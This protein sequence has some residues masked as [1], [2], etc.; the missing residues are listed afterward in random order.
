MPPI[1]KAR[2]V[3]KNVNFEVA[4]V[5]RLD[6]LLGPPLELIHDSRCLKL[7]GYSDGVAHYEEVQ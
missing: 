3:N 1:V 6:G 2:I 7:L 5:K 4:L